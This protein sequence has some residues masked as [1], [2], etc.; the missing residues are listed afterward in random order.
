MAGVTSSLDRHSQLTRY[1]TAFLKS[2]GLKDTF[3]TLCISHGGNSR[4]HRDL[5]DH[6]K[7]LNHTIGVGK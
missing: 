7:S 6:D 5:W 3:T 2:R 4:V 1:L